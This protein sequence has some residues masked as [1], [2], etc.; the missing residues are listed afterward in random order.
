MFLTSPSALADFPRPPNF[1]PPALAPTTG[2]IVLLPND[3]SEWRASGVLEWLKDRDRLRVLRLPLALTD[4]LLSLRDSAK[5]GSDPFPIAEHAETV[6]NLKRQV[7]FY[8]LT[9]G[10]CV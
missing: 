5:E 6:T 3:A 10:L 7:S 4:F 8:R 1:A 9:S 2:V